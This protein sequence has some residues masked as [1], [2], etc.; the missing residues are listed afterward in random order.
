MQ[1]FPASFLLLFYQVSLGGLFALAV[2]PFHELE[3]GFYKSTGAVLFLFALL[4]LW[5]K[6]DLFRR[7]FSASEIDLFQSGKTLWCGLCEFPVFIDCDTGYDSP[8]VQ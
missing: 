2:T 5:G 7:S 4:G 6:A 3:R 8:V 1:A